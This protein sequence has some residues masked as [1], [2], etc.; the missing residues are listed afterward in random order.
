MIESIQLEGLGELQRNLQVF[1]GSIDKEIKIIVSK[2]T[3]GTKRNIAKQITERLATQVKRTSEVIDIVRRPSVSRPRGHVQ[4]EKTARLPLKHFGA[5]Q[6]RKGVTY[7]IDKRGQRKTHP[8]AFI[9][10]QVAH[11][12]RSRTPS[13]RLRPQPRIRHMGGHVFA[14]AYD[15]PRKLIKQFALS[16]WGMYV[17]NP[18]QKRTVNEARETARKELANRVSFAKFRRRQFKRAPFGLQVPRGLKL[19]R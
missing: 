15:N 18:M 10:S 9:P 8:T 3:T 1:G 19:N 6:T 5:R 11:G 13:G 16:P 4:L 2:T 14:R 12:P 7:R 17:E